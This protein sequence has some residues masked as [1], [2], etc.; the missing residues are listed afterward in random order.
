MNGRRLLFSVH[1]A[2]LAVGASLITGKAVANQVIADNLIVQ[3][4]LCVGLDCLSTESFGFDTI[5]LKENN[6]RIKFQDTSVGA[7]P[8][9]D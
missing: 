3:G 8:S 4:S 7:F 1:V 5:R 9:N 6:L 2:A